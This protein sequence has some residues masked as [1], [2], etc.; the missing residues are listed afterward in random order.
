MMAHVSEVIRGWLGWCPNAPV[1]RTTS[2]VFAAHP[3]TVHPAQPDGGIG[4]SGRIN[5]GIT[6]AVESTK[7]LIRNKRLFWFSFLTGLVILFMFIAELS[8]MVYSGSYSYWVLGFRPGLVLTF[9]IEMISV[10]SLYFLL[11]GL[12]MSVSPV[13]PGRPVTL[14]D[15]LSHARSHMRS[16]AGWSVIMALCGTAL[17]TIAVH[18]QYF[19]YLYPAIMTMTLY[20]PFIYYIPDI[21][22]SALSFT[23]IKILINVFLFILTL[24]VV[25]VLVLENTTLPDAV[26]GSL[27]L[28]KKVWAEIIV[29]SLIFCLALLGISSL[30]LI[31]RMTPALVNYDYSFFHAQGWWMAIMV[32]VYVLVWW[33]LAIIGST[34]IGISTLRL[35]T[36]GKTGTASPVSEEKPV[37]QVPV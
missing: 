35:Y 29:C 34:V 5:R 3:A 28:M 6:C 16:I 7:T 13:L 21:I 25:P 8:L 14:R 20:I 22:L 9:V 12:I 15:G 27:S 19:S 26:A 1:M 33:I 17:Y 10:F 18:N 24:F 36:Y 4:G 31:I 11:A 30:D 32:S 2:A 23:F 37:V